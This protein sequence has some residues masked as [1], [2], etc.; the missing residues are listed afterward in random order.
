MAPSEK[1][2]KDLQSLILDRLRE[3]KGNPL[4]PNIY[5]IGLLPD[6]VEVYLEINTKYWQNEFR[7]YISNSPYIK[8]SG[9]SKPTPI[10]ELVDSVVELDNVKLLPDRHSF[11]VNSKTAS[12]TLTNESE[13]DIS[14][15]E[16]YLIGYKG[17]DGLWYRL[18]NPGMWHDIGIELKPT[19]KYTFDASL[20]PLLNNNQP[21]AYRLYKSIRF[22]GEKKKV[23]LMTEFIL[24]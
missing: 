2:L 19:G 6:T 12:F 4:Q 22:E 20:T 13:N 5:G 18:P 11:S 9:D 15:G 8:F 24:E 16:Y 23:W 14:F 10:S 7:K 1:E 21:G 3:I 17:N